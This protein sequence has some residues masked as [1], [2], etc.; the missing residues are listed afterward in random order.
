MTE[1]EGSATERFKEEQEEFS[2]FDLDTQQFIT[3]SLL[4]ATSP[5]EG[6]PLAARNL[7]GPVALA[8]ADIYRMLEGAR[9]KLPKSF[10]QWEMVEF[11]GYA[12]APSAF[13]LSLGKL[14]AFDAYRF[15]YERILG[16]G[17]RPWLPSLYIAAA[18]APSV[19]RD[20]SRRAVEQ[21]P[22]EAEIDRDW[23]T[24]DPLFMPG[25]DAVE[26]PLS[27]TKPPVLI[28]NQ[29]GEEARTV[30]LSA[31]PDGSLRL[32]SSDHGPTAQRMY[33]N[34]DYEFWFDIPPHAMT[35]LALVL[36]ADRLHGD[37]NAG[38]R[39]REF[40]EQNEI[41]YDGGTWS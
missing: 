21:F 18:T 26:P 40:C 33:G 6:L 37:P 27:G 28:A 34:S 15:L 5:E 11:F 10:A 22:W 4:L 36:L 32:Q 9:S 16:G 30:T 24:L 8:Q 17:A 41:E 19:P 1:T 13:D 12:L 20:I 3:C 25:F 39:L 29:E 35:N 31:L 7:G 38:Q 2:Q 14:T 23:H